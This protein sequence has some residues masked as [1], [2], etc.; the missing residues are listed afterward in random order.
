LNIE[1]AKIRSLE[2]THWEVCGLQNW[3]TIADEIEKI[4]ISIEEE[5]V[6]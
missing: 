6:K 2:D 4:G 1:T 3:Q 5:D